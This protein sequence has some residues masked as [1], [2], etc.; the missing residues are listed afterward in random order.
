[1]RMKV[2]LV[3]PKCGIT[4]HKDKSEYIRNQ[5]KGR[6]S[7]CSLNCA[8]RVNFYK[9]IPEEKRSKYD[10]SKHA[11]DNVDE[12]TDFR[13]TFKLLKCRMKKSCD[14]SLNDLKELW[15]FQGGICP[16]TGIKLKLMK[17]GYA[18]SDITNSRFEIASLDRIDS[19]KGYIKGNVCYVSM[20]INFMKNNMGVES[21]V[22]FMRIIAN[23]MNDKK[24]N[25]IV[26]AVGKLME[27]DGESLI[28]HNDVLLHSQ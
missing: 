6:E 20:M 17:H 15:E 7:Y 14:L 24:D 3:C 19:S 27:F 12:Y 16:Y 25:D 11:H 10:I 26:Y 18:F 22:D 23:Y 1:M 2:E 13:Y 5:K 21:T 28:L 8:S 4:Y 9:N